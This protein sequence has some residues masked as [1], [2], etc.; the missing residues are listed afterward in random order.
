[1]ETQIHAYSISTTHG[2]VQ[3]RAL[4]SSSS[5]DKGTNSAGSWIGFG[6]ALHNVEDLA[7]IKTWPVHC[8]DQ[9]T[10]EPNMKVNGGVMCNIASQ[11]I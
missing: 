5:S 3:F 4:A 10:A 7:F 2:S 9:R 11:I 1:M 6:A 8:I